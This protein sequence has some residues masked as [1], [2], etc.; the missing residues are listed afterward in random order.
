MVV[1]GPDEAS[2]LS[3]Q[4]PKSRLSINLEAVGQSLTAVASEVARVV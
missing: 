4:V 1:A 3:S 2:I